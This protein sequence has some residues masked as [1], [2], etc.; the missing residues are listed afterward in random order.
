[1]DATGKVLWEEPDFTGN[2]LADEGEQ[3]I[4]NVYLLEASNPTKY[5]GL[6][7]DG[8]LAE[9]DTVATVT[10]ADTPGTHGYNRQQILN[11]DWAAATLNSGDY[12]STAAQKT[13]GPISGVAV[14]AT[15]AFVTTTSTGTG[16]KFIL[17]IALSAT[18][19]IAVGQSFLYTL[20]FKMQ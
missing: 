4:I 6:L 16:G 7:N 13:F 20:T 18:T 17:Y 8:T 12:Q 2:S 9:T 5:L 3:S 10:E 1:V 14:T 19:T 11:T 15:T